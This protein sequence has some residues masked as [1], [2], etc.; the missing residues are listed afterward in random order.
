MNYQALDEALSYIEGLTEEID[1]EA[2]KD[3]YYA[4][5]EIAAQV[6]A[7]SEALVRYPGVFEI[8]NLDDEDVVNFISNKLNIT[9][10]YFNI[11]NTQVEC[12]DFREVTETPEFKQVFDFIDQELRQRI[13]KEV[14]GT[15]SEYLGCWD[16]GPFALVLK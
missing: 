1:I 9:L 15:S 4:A 6:L 13:E 7:S 8:V 16:E 5:K 3:K 2:C 10:I 12:G 14:P 11:R